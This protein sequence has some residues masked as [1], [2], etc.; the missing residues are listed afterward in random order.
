VVDINRKWARYLG[1]TTRER[2]SKQLHLTEPEMG[3]NQ[4]E[5]KR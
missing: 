1:Q 5:T 2:Q 3:M 4:A